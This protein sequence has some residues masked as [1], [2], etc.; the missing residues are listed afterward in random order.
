MLL[1]QIK[2]REYRFKLALRMGLPIFA[3]V[4][5]F[6]IHLF[7][8][9][10]R[11][12]DEH[13][14]IESIVVLLVSIYFIF[15]LIY[16]G[17]DDKITNNVSK[18]FTRAYIYKHI[19]KN[20]KSNEDYTYLLISIDNLRD[21]N[22]RYGVK[23]ADKILF[24]VSTWI[25][26][27]LESKDI[28]K[29]PIGHINGADFLVELKG[30]NS[31]YKVLLEMLCLKGDEFKI[32]NI[33]VKI[34]AAT[35]NTTL[36]RELDYLVEN[37]FEIQ[38][39]NRHTKEIQNTTQEMDPSELE[40]YVIEALKERKFLTMTQN[41]I[42]NDGIE[43]KELFVK[44]QASNGKLIHPK[45]YI[46]VLDKLRL[47]SDFDLMV[48]EEQIMLKNDLSSTTLAINISPTSIRDPH[49]V[50]K[51]KELFH[52]NGEARMKIIFLL[53]EKEHFSHNS[54]YN[55]ILQSLRKSGILVAIDRLGASHSSFLYLRDLDV[56]IVRFD[57]VYSK[58]QD[59]KYM[60]VIHGLNTMA[61]DMGIKTWIKM[62][63]NEEMYKDIETLNIEYIQGNYFGI[64][65][66]K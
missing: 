19:N 49:F 32:D 59:I 51:V 23:N 30:I 8:Q 43:V 37:L 50:Q 20:L 14:Y 9:T 63:E 62:I 13:F 39:Q 45:A 57:S 41:V 35:N 22:S 36:S 5:T 2:E 11:T 3:L 34:S 16:K 47:M 52:T 42:N 31:E 21:I 46:K 54:R 65:E 15:Y 53:Y 64:L 27:Y 55:M 60:G 25:S 1:S 17:F 6:I 4:S 24:E 61:K 48:L 28:K 38:E 18:A 58:N 26:E 56:D 33:E 40:L 44:L 29:A 7:L 10:E 66:K 12:F